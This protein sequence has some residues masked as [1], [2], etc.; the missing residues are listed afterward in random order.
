MNKILT[1]ILL[2][3]SLLMYSQDSSKFEFYF[4]KRM[5]MVPSIYYS[6]E[7]LYLIDM[8]HEPPQKITLKLSKEDRS[9]LLGKLKEIKFW[10][11]PEYYEIEK[12]TINNGTG[13]LVPCYSYNL[14]VYFKNRAKE[15]SWSDCITILHSKNNQF[16]NLMELRKL[17]D[18]IIDGN[19]A[20]KNAKRPKYL[21][22]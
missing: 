15:V 14:T 13:G 17:L 4:S 2:F 11:Y 5:G 10:N 12:D 22:R 9:E 20:A 6:S 1:I 8:V 21:Y 16:E 3:N 19:P 18:K 7:N